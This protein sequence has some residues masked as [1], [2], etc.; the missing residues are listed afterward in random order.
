MM[1]MM[2]GMLMMLLLLLV[3]LQMLLGSGVV[4]SLWV[5]NL[6]RVWSLIVISADTGIVSLRL[7]CCMIL[8]GSIIGDH[9]TL[10]QGRFQTVGQLMEHLGSH[11]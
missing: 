9:G 5:A 7:V 3:V 6:E 2:L 11:L 1:M 8:Y 4:G 10:Q